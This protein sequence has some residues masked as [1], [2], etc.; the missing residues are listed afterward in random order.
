MKRIVTEGVPQQPIQIVLFLRLP[1]WNLI[2]IH[3]YS[4][5]FQTKGL[6][7]QPKIEV[8]QKI[9]VLGLLLSFVHRVPENGSLY[10]EAGFSSHFKE[11]MPSLGRKQLDDQVRELCL[12]ICRMYLALPYFSCHHGSA[13]MN[14]N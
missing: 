12:L 14:K 3:Q 8:L 1:K 2:Q 10:L 4:M 5:H 6:P 11:C 9:E 13:Q 7:L